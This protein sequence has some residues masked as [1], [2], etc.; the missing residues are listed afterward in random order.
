[1]SENV[2]VLDRAT[3]DLFDLDVRDLPIP[4]ILGCDN[5]TGD[6]CSASCP[7]V[8]CSATCKSCK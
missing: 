3:E 1:M 5:H 7:S 8:G 2:A 6:G 4:D